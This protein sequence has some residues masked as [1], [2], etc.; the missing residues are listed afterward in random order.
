MSAGTDGL[1]PRVAVVQ[2]IFG[3]WTAQAIRAMATLGLADHL[4]AGP[5]TV[6]SLARASG[7]HASSLARLLRALVAL[8]LCARDAQG[9]V[10]LTPIGELL[11]SDVAAS[12]R[13]SAQMI[14]APWVMRV[15]EELAACVRTGEPVFERVH[16]SDF[17]EYLVGHA[18][19]R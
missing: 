10:T 11:R 13:A 3:S 18:A 19:N 7:T 6:E 2:M 5:H 15:W 12:Q 8:N 4:A 14:S 17:W 16:G 1:S 9:R